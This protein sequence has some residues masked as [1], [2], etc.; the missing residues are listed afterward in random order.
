MRLVSR[1][2]VVL[3]LLVMARTA[4]AQVIETPVPFDSAGKI[5]TLTPSLVTRLGLT[6][7]A[8]PATG[9]FTEARL[10]DI[11][12]GGQVLVVERDNGSIE[13]Y[14]L[15]PDHFTALRFAVDAGMQRSGS[16]VSDERADPV[17]QP[18]RGAFVRNQM[19]LTWGVYG[20]LLAALADDPKGGTALVLLATGASYFATTALSR[21]AVITVSQNHLAIDGA[22]RGLGVGTGLLYAAAGDADSRSYAAA[23]LV[24][25]LA[26]QITGFQL[27]KRLTIGEAEAATS[28]STYAAATAMGVAGASGLINEVDDGRGAIAATIGA[29]LVGY[30]L[31]PSYPRRARY[32]VTRGDVQLLSTGAILGIGVGVTP[33]LRDN[34][35]DEK[36]FFASATA[37]ML[38][39]LLLVERGWVRPFDHSA[40]DAAE[41]SVGMGAG[42]LMGAGVG[43]LTDASVQAMVGLMT[44][45]GVLGALVAHN[46]A[47]PARAG[48]TRVGQVHGSRGAKLSWEPSALALAASKVPGQHAFL[49]LTF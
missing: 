15:T 45:G 17:S 2:V 5:R 36:P 33:F 37:G 10:F 18:A 27:G 21:K 29:G 28:I 26:G 9:V 24:G 12:T 43:V 8:W 23:G 19:L 41:T 25:A 4:A 38:G 44:G 49:R 39:G 47:A 3:F 35:P 14:L 1:S 22:V 34:I 48:T 11:S 7:P 40:R 13:R 16:P 46:L 30:A 6:A 42:A 32:T 31:G 20:P